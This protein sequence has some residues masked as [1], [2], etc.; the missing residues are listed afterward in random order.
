MNYQEFKKQLKEIENQPKKPTLLLH[1]CCGPCS[2]YVLTFLNEYFEITIFYYNPNI[3]PFEEYKKRL[4]VQK[5]IIQ[6]LKLDV[7]I[8]TLEYNYQ[9]YTNVVKGFEHL[10]EKSQ[11]CYNCYEFRLLK[12]SEIASLYNFDYF[13]TTLSISPYK[14]S[15]WINEI[16]YKVQRVSKYLYSNFKK[17]EGYKKSISLSK[18][19]NLYRQDYCG[20]PY[21]L[22]EHLEHIKI[23][24]EI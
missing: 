24:K 9:E 19:Y 6:K 17:E 7:K 13:T 3:Y 10:G 15:E 23:K 18:E 4:E 20:C 11:R 21:S 14:N 22:Q 1:S 5:E 12:T 8:I 2:S 16:G